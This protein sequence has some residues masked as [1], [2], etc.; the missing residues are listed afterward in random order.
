MSRAKPPET[1]ERR[2]VSKTAATLTGDGV[3]PPNLPAGIRQKE[4]RTWWKSIWASPMAEEWLE[5]DRQSLL[6]LAV[7]VDQF[8]MMTLT[9]LAPVKE[10]IAEIAKQEARFGLTPYDRHRM[11]W[12]VEKPTEKPDLPVAD[13]KV[14]PRTVLRAV[15]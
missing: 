10:L 14:D 4:T 12:K 1:R 13:P 7:L 11:Q 15:K 8:W 5:S 2:N 3:K 9:P 6:R